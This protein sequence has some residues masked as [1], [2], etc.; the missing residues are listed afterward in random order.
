MRDGGVRS[1]CNPPYRSRT[2]AMTLFR[3]EV[4][5]ARRNSWL[6]GISLAQ[7]VRAW[8]LASAAGIV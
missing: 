4:L 5:Q 2:H 7:P 8:V 6:G 1:P 3:Q